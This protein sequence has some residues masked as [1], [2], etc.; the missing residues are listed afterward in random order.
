[1]I[2][3]LLA[4]QARGEELIA[5]TQIGVRHGLTRT[6]IEEILPMVAAY[7]GFPAAMA[8]SREI[9][10]GLRLIEGVEQLSPRTR[11]AAK[12]DAERERDAARVRAALT[13][14]PEQDPVQDLAEL[15]FKL[16]DLG[17]LTYRWTLGEIWAR[18]ELSLRDRSIVV[19]S[20]LTALVA[21]QMLPE[22]IEGG[23]RN[24]LRREEIEEMLT[25]LGLYAGLAHAAA[26]MLVAKAVFDTLAEGESP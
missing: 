17:G 22:Y 1:M 23:L 12:S 25:H 21:E 2:V 20:I 18:P 10:E 16:G 6:E 5:H 3:S 4:T 14:L 26:A 8:A 9:D 7:A 13:G 11:A 24:G 19:I 15:T